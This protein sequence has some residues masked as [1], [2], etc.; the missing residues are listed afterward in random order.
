MNFLAPK[1]L[2]LAR[3]NAR[4]FGLKKMRRFGMPS[5]PARVLS[6]SA[7]TC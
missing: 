3:K 1:V 6:S 2:R 5:S 4:R 7:G